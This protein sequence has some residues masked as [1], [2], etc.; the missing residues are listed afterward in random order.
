MGTFIN[1][2]S[3]RLEIIKF[4][5]LIEMNNNENL[6]VYRS[7]VITPYIENVQDGI[8]HLFVLNSNNKMVDPS[9]E[10]SNDKFNQNI[11]NLYPEYDRDN[12]NDNPPEAN[13]FAKNFPIGDVV[14]NDLKKSIT[15]E[16]TNNFISG[17]DVSNTISLLINKQQYLATLTFDKEHSFESLKYVSSLSGGSGHTPASGQATYHNIKLLN[18]TSTPPTNANWDGA[19][20]MV[21]VQ[22]G[23]AIA[24]TITDGGSG[25]K[26]GEQLYFDSSD[27]DNWW[28][29][30][31]R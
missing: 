20:A 17:F 15:R 25:Y 14:T 3:T 1:T 22:N 6:F 29:W 19:T 11:V 9:N 31:K 2:T 24:A 10:F 12:V 30:W 26:N 4:L 28:Y 16:T 7:T 27:V 5:E 13:S 18:N 8:Y 23:V 21:T